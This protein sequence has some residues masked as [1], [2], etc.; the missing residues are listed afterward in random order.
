FFR[1]VF[2]LGCT[3]HRGIFQVLPEA[4]KT[5]FFRA[6][7]LL[8]CTP[9]RGIF[10]VLLGVQQTTFRERGGFVFSISPQIFNLKAVT[11][12]KG[13]SR[14]FLFIIHSP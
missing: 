13:K 9:H 6:V 7:F 14:L 8:G 10:Q 2:L 1:A 3:P 5:A 4:L 12:E 11:N